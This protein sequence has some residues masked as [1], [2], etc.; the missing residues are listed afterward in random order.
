MQ[1]KDSIKSMI[2]AAFVA[3]SLLTGAV[4]SYG[5]FVLSAARNFVTDTYDGALM[6]VS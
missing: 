5:L 1:V 2:F 6:A 3:M 4:G